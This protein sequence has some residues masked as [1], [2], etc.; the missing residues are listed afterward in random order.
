MDLTCSCTA[1]QCSEWYDCCLVLVVESTRYAYTVYLHVLKIYIKKKK[2]ARP[3]VKKMSMLVEPHTFFSLALLIFLNINF[4]FENN[5]RT[6]Y[7]IVI[8]L[9]RR[10]TSTE[11]RLLHDFVVLLLVHSVTLTG[12]VHSLVLAIRYFWYLQ[13]TCMESTLIVT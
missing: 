12:A 4:A 2:S 6:T 8:V 7:Y 1:V 10:C 13:I 11:A 3:P 9:D 5:W